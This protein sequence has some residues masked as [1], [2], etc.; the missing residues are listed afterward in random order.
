MAGNQYPPLAGK[1]YSETYDAFIIKTRQKDEYDKMLEPIVKAFG[2]KPVSFLS[3]GAGFGRMEDVLVTKYG[4][5][6]SFYYAIEPD[7]THSKKLKDTVTSWGVEYKIDT[8]YFS[9][10][11]DISQKFDV[12]FIPQ[13]LYCFQDPFQALLHAK[14]FLNPGGRLIIL[15]MSSASGFYQIFSYFWEKAGKNVQTC[16]DHNNMLVSEDV[17]RFLAKSGIDCQVKND[18]MKETLEI[19]DFV[20]QIMYNCKYVNNAISF[21]LQTRF[22]NLS[23][24]LKNDILQKAK[25]LCIKDVDGKYVLPIEQTMIEICGK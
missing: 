25:D 24:S 7:P 16:Y 10:D 21:I 14:S 4:L 8:N 3:I 11:M 22:E 20:K 5:K 17:I 23:P 9:S 12:I 15:H 19:D 1:E 6:M 2:S 18:I 13:S